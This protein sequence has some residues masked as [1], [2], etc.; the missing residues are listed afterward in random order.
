MKI[1]YRT[2]AF[3][4]TSR[5]HWR[6]TGYRPM[7]WSLWYPAVEVET[8]QPESF[9][10]LGQVAI[11]APFSSDKPHPL[12]FL[13]HGTGGVTQSLSWLARGLVEAGYIVAGVNHHGNCGGEPY[14]AEGF[15]C[16]WERARDTSILLD[17]LLNGDLQEKIDMTRIAHVGF[18]LGGYT[19]IALAGA[20]TSMEVFDAWNATLPS[21]MRGPK[22][23]ADMADELETLRETSTTFQ[24]SMKRH[25]DNYA[26]DRICTFVAIA[27]AP[28]VQAFTSQSLRAIS[29][30][31]SLITGGAD[32][33]A[34]KEICSD[35][36]KT[37]N[38]DFRYHN[39]GEHVGHYTFLSGPT[40]VGLKT[41]LDIFQDHPNVERFDVQTTTLQI[42][43]ATLA[44]DLK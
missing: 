33:E 13:S 35:W 12:V 43:T 38:P 25:T 9:F 41:K 36:L 5:P 27:P 37:Q 42:I 1:G 22:E 11:N 8:L 10:D 23:F 2:G 24:A 15:S 26:D 4:D 18:S 39:V 28:T 7:V 40:K 29:R 30:P 19:S 34:P 6:E 31:V 32:Q 21:P 44:S 16:W 14:V 17:H 3:E 20:R